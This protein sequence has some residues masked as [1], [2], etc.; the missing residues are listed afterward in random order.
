L[1][2]RVKG[3]GGGA[4]II[5]RL[6]AT[7]RAYYG[8]LLAHVGVAVFVIGVTLVKGYEMEKDVRMAPGDTVEL[9]GHVFRFEGVGDAKGPNY[10]AARATLSV[11]REGRAVATLHP[12]RRVYRVQESPMT[13]SAIDYGLFRHLYVALS[14]PVGADAWIVRVHYK[15]LV[16]WIWAGCLLM[17]LGG[18]LAA[19]DRRYRLGAREPRPAAY[20]AEAGAAR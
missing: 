5:N 16:A 11:M 2:D 9:G 6:R 20:A 3:T 19:S 8:M 18:L 17:A 13:E 1:A 12:E 4:G 15:P 10:L 7:P 14:E